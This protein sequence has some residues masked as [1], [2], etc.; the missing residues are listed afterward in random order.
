MVFSDSEA[1]LVQLIAGKL[2]ANGVESIILN[3]KDSAYNNFGM[4]ELYVYKKDIVKAKFI[5]SQKKE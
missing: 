3:T 5:I 1:Y 4:V 2:E